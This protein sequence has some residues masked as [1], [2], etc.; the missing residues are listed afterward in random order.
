MSISADPG[1]LLI[2]ATKAKQ[3]N[4]WA[5]A[6]Y[7]YNTALETN[8]LSDTGKILTYWN[9]FSVEY[10]LENFNNYMNALSAFVIY[11][12]NFKLEENLYMEPFDIPGKLDYANIFIQSKWAVMNGYSCK[13]KKFICKAHHRNDIM[14]YS[15]L[16]PFC[17]DYELKNIEIVEDDGKNIKLKASCSSSTKG[18]SYYEEYYFYYE[19]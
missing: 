9:I 4:D 5:T 7:Y 12:S 11:A 1:A 8:M 3:N 10:E 15:V 18:Y 19:H 17:K 6:S 16:M 13:S 2:E 14:M